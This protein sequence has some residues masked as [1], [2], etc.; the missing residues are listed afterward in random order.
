MLSSIVV[1]KKEKGESLPFGT[2]S[3]FIQ[4]QLL[5]TWITSNCG[6]NTINKCL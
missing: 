1:D 5:S 6:R 4:A 3:Y 2:L